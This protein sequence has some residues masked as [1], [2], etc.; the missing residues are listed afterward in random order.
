MSELFTHLLTFLAWGCSLAMT[1]YTAYF[2]FIALFSLQKARRYPEK[3]PEARFAVLVAARNEEA[4]IGKLVES[5]LC[6]NYPRERYDVIVVPNN[7]TDGTG[8]VAGEA[9]A[10]VLECTVPTSSKGEVLDFA[11]GRIL[12]WEKKYDAVCV[13][14]AD[15]LVHPDFLRRM[16]DAWQ[17]GARV[18]Q[19]YRDS[20]NPTDSLISG[21]YSIYYW[22]VN[23]F[24]SQAR[25]NLGLNAI[26]NGSG[27]MVSMDILQKA[28]GWKT[29]TITEDI[30]FSAICAM[31]GEKIWW[32]PEAVT[33]D[34]QPLTFGQS[35]K[36]R[37]RW[38]TGM[39]QCMERYTLPLAAGAARGN[40]LSFDSLMFFILPVVQ[41]LGL[42]AMGGSFVFDL[43][44]VRYGL[45]PRTDLFYRIFFAVNLSLITTF[46]GA[47][48]AVA[49]NGKPV[50][51]M[52]PAMLWYWVFIMS[53]L[54][55]NLLCLVKKATVWE[56]IPH[57]RAIQLA[58]LE[59]KAPGRS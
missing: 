24:Y 38:S 11:L 27:F 20:K 1:A 53:W 56:E 16:N 42:L 41:V 19:G 46:L 9:G 34:E 13:F 17:A 3:A 30:E 23:R 26:V 4:V 39:I 47:F 31:K 52:L 5:L 45:F 32:V 40:R 8:R 22:M 33:F 10:M 55:I 49:A 28:G 15:N 57:T 18:A 59:A 35:W 2:L 50:G 14:D 7:C 58:Q 51:R 6:Q 43:F 29:A 21:C 36:Q 12:R 54:P 25:A 37:K 48:L 44:G